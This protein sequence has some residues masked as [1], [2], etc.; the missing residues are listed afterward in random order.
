MG[1][2]RIGKDS[3]QVFSQDKTVPLWIIRLFQPVSCKGTVVYRSIHMVAQMVLY[4]WHL[5]KL[6]LLSENQMMHIR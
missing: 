2:A 6:K 5:K 3:M 1:S 4:R